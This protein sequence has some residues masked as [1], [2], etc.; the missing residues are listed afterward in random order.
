MGD[1]K[2]VSYE[3]QKHIDMNVGLNTVKI[4]DTIDNSYPDSCPLCESENVD[5]DDDYSDQFGGGAPVE[6]YTIT[7]SC[8]ACHKDTDIDVTIV[9]THTVKDIRDNE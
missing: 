7:V 3:E 1:N 2:K 8:N 9:E 4:G 5:I 6:R